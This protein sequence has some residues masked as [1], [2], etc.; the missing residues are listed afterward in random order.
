MKERAAD[1]CFGLLHWW[2]A[3]SIGGS[4]CYRKSGLCR[5]KMAE[6]RQS[7]SGWKAHVGKAFLGRISRDME[8]R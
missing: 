5:T 2:P 6:R 4:L 7:H 1:G 3:G 8:R